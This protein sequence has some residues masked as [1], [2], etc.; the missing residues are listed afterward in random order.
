VIALAL[1]FSAYE[2][3]QAA[4]IRA[5]FFTATAERAI[6]C[7]AGRQTAMEPDPTEAADAI[8]ITVPLGI[9]G[10]CRREASILRNH[11][12]AEV[13]APG[14]WKKILLA[15]FQFGLFL[16][17]ALAWY[18]TEA[19]RR[20]G[21]PYVVALLAFLGLRAW[22]SLSPRHMQVVPRGYRERKFRFYRSLTTMQRSEPFTA[23]EIKRYQ[24]DA[25]GLIASFVR[26]HRAD[27]AGTT[28]FANL[29]VEDGDDLV[30]VAR[31]RPHRQPQC[32]HPKVG[33]LAWRCIS[34]GQDQ[35]SGDIYRDFPDTPPGKK[36]LSVLVTPIKASDGRVLGAVSV[37]SSKAYHFD[38][39]FN[40]LVV[41]LSPYVAL[42]T[43]TLDPNSRIAKPVVLKQEG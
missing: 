33:M 32:R 31:D 22:Y 12:R 21:V 37:D 41:F 11:L 23:A 26:D 10:T 3:A 7:R 30:V 20:F 17:P 40:D 4:G 14:L 29:L 27:K 19:G 5:A 42:L 39:E 1:C 16:T 28:I 43:W 38:T 15:L 35:V 8:A 13:R 2:V 18:R 6:T 25:L 24:E 36:Y 9:W 34:S